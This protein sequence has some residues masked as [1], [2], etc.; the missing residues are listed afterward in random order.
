VASRWCPIG[1]AGVTLTGVILD[2]VGEVGDKLRSLC[3]IGPSRWHRHRTLMECPAARAA[4][5]D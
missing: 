2:L 5:L 4:D 3:Q 1:R